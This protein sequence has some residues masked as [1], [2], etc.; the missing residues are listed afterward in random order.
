MLLIFDWDGTLADSESHIVAALQAGIAEMRLEYRSH[1]DC[2]QCI[3]LGLEQTARR[4]FPEIADS[5]LDGFRAVY[6]KNYLLLAESEYRLNL[7]DG[8]EA[9]LD[10]LQSQ[11]HLL[12]VATGKSRVGLD[13]VLQE[14]GLAGRF[15]STRAADETASKPDPLMLREI[16]HE[17]AA[18]VD[19]ALMIGDSTYDL[20]MAR[21]LNM[22]RV[23]VSY[24]VHSIEQLEAFQPVA[25]VH[26]IS[27]LT[28][29]I[30]GLNSG[31]AAS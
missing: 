29:V 6:S 16:L 28:A 14:S 12:A 25:M 17:Q 2:A 5:E 18:L 11:G 15:V 30:E 19:Q 3:G 31:L 9:C 7:F 20:E 4:L 8:V 22:A 26:Q 24:G 13:R 1:H 10:E 21:N 27:E 23:G